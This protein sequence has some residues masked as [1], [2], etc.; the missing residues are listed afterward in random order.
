[1]PRWQ[2]HS[3]SRCL[4]CA[5]LPFWRT[6]RRP[7]HY[8]GRPFAGSGLRVRVLPD[9]AAPE[10]PGT[11]PA[12][13]TQPPFRT[14][15][16]AQPGCGSPSHHIQNRG[17]PQNQFISASLH[18]R[19]GVTSLRRDLGTWDTAGAWGQVLQV[20]WAAVA[21]F[22]KIHGFCGAL[23]P[24]SAL[25]RPFGNLNE[26]RLQNQRVPDDEQTFTGSLSV[27]TVATG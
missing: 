19:H 11:S 23:A 5:F 6:W 17:T 4:V 9:P 22:E 25:G 18:N 14:R 27:I 12:R 10:N 13:T 16:P 20:C 3:G 15:E 21:T 26:A 7:G 1:V 24:C 8:P 2:A